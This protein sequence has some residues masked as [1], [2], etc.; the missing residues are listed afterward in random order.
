MRSKPRIVFVQAGG[1][2]TLSGVQHPVDRRP[3]V[4]AEVV[5]GSRPV[6]TVDTFARRHVV[7]VPGCDGGGHGLEPPCS[8]TTTRCCPGRSQL[9]GRASGVVPCRSRAR[10]IAAG[11][12]CRR[13]RWRIRTPSNV[14]SLTFAIS[15]LEEAKAHRATLCSVHGCSNAQTSLRWPG[16]AVRS[17]LLQVSVLTRLT[18]A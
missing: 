4:R 2:S 18:R 6:D 8:T 7:V 5:E 17:R 16:L 9:A 14:S 1:V 15:S 13:C 3:A 10:T 12:E 11:V